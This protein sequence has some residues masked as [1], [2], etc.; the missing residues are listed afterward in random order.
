MTTA[1]KTAVQANWTP[2]QTQE[3]TV[4]VMA[5]NC[6]AAFQVLSKYGEEAVTEYQTVSR[7]LRV[8]RLKTLGV[9]TPEQLVKTLAEFETNVFGSKIATTGDEKTATLTYESCAMWNAMKKAG[10][11]TPEQ[12]EKMGESFQSCMTSLGKEFN[13]KTDVK[14]EGEGATITFTK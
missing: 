7:Q 11:F 3:A 14:F 10:K 12:E 4:A 13:L 8:D 9:T 6:L 2:A 5:A 1:T